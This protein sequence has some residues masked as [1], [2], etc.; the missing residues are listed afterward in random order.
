[1][2]NIST[3]LGKNIQDIFMIYFDVVTDIHIIAVCT[4]FRVQ[5][6]CYKFLHG[7]VTN[8][9][10]SKIIK[11]LPFVEYMFNVFKKTA[12]SSCYLS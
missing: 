3:C 6:T 2:L 5:Y 12:G 1:M 8:G 4:F 9:F 11:Y 10:S 7:A